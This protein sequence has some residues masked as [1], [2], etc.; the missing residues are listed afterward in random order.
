MKVVFADF[1]MHT[2]RVQYG[3]IKSLELNF[4]ETLDHTPILTVCLFCIKLSMI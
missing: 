1:H 3:E 4:D 2:Q